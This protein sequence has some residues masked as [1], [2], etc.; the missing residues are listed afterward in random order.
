VPGPSGAT[1]VYVGL[2]FA[3][4]LLTVIGESFD[5][6]VIAAVVVA[7][8]PWGLVAA[9]VRVA[10]LLFAG[11][12]IAPVIAVVAGTGVGSAMFLSLTAASRVASQTDR[13]SVVAALTA[14]VIAL[15]FV[16]FLPFVPA[17]ELD[18]GA[19][20]F[21]FGGAFAVL[22]GVLLR[23]TT[24]LADELRRADA[25]L[26]K[27]VARD[28]RH[29]IARDVHD[30]VA[31]SLT[32]VVLHIGGARRVLRSDPGAAEKALSDAERVSRE[33][34]DAIRGAVGLLREDGEPHVQSL[35]LERLITTYRSAGM[36]IAL[37]LAGDPESLPLPVRVTVYRV[38]QEALAN[39]ARHSGPNA[40]TR[41]DV[42]IERDDVAV[43][44]SNQVGEHAV[45]PPSKT[46]GYGLL[47]LRE[48]AVSIGGHLT[49]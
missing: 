26:A 8:V 31:H 18:V 1:P 43:R 37:H 9:G 35:D 22:V 30:L 27:A 21:A 13:R 39:V 28:E 11:V 40:T 24:R 47:G 3:A 45:Q 36:P 49:S 20:Y 29:R 34:L 44:I 38:V 46:G 2:A 41:V 7:L 5:P 32:V 33:S 16:T 25:E 14:V 23:R 42:V 48:Q 6:F 17:F 4:A 12:A 19:V 10:H 15:P